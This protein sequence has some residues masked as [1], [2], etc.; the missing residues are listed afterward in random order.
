M[1][2]AHAEAGSQAYDVV[3]VGGGIIGLS[4]ARALL[5]DRP[6]ARVAIVEKEPLLAAHQTGRNSGVIH[7]GIYYKPGSLK[8]RTVAR[9]RGALLDFCDEHGVDYDIC[10][11]V[12][13]ATDESEQQALATLLDK[14][15]SNGVR[16]EL[17]DPDRL[18]ELEPAV[19]GVAALHVP[20]AGI[21]DYTRV[22]EVIAGL[23]R[24]Q[25][26]DILLGTAVTGIDEDNSGVVVQ[27]SRGVLRGHRLVNCAGLQS[28]RVAALSADGKS[29]VHIVP[30]RGEYYE[31]VPSR[32]SLI[33]NL[34]YPVPD[35]A[36]PFLGVHF[37]RMIDGGVHA[38][39]NAVLA[40][41]RE[42]YDWSTFSAR[43]TWETLRH[44]GFRRLARRHAWTGLGEMH[45][46]VS[47]AAFVRALQRLV[48][49][50]GVTDL[51]RSK[52]G[53]RAQ[54][55]ESDGTMVDDFAI[56]QTSRAVHVV[57]APSP[58]AT[59]SLEIGRI[60]AEHVTAHITASERKSIWEMNR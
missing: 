55:L 21:V 58:A 14:A 16:A 2:A 6:G 41:A 60:I 28:D 33:R 46:S 8:A 9:G 45:R 5:L 24:G 4:V 35:P 40:L 34:V 18:R 47:K 7:S 57:N 10:G 1:E 15:R 53:V 3:V 42:G 32:R 30:F 17:I 23:L 31:L 52:A 50:V 29:Q 25:G 19:R 22:C 39:P 43:D 51:V 48:P 36:F 12:I 11:K 59:A 49:D 13:V 37:T 26:V 20:D 38:G 27:T 44:P 56:A 54:A